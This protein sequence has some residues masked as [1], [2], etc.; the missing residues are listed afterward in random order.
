M[1]YASLLIELQL[2]L[3]D[4]FTYVEAV[5]ICRYHPSNFPVF[6]K[7]CI[8]ISPAWKERKSISNRTKETTC[9][10]NIIC[11]VRNY[12]PS[13]SIIGQLPPEIGFLKMIDDI[14]AHLFEFGKDNES[15]LTVFYNELDRHIDFKSKDMER[16]D[17]YHE[18]TL[19][20]QVKLKP[21]TFQI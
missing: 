7:Y 15:N 19:P 20:Y 21:E 5:K 10:I 8:L 1:D 17:F 14:T 11:I 9:G 12:H 4:A 13:L 6:D 2:Y 16:E 3:K 18:I